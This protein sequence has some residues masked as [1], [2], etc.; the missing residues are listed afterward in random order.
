MNNT[1]NAK[2]NFVKQD[3]LKYSFKKWLF[4]EH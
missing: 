4:R 3:L 1:N 2:A